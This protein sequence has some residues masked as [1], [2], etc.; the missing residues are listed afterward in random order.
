[1]AVA[2]DGTV[3][4][5]FAR[6][7]ANPPA[8]FV[9]VAVKP[10]GGSFGAPVSL[11]PGYSPRLASDAEGNVAVV[12]EQHIAGTSIVTG[13]TRRAGGSFTPVQKISDTGS[14]A[15]YPQV[16]IAG[17]KAVVVWQQGVYQRERVRA[18]S[19]EAGEPFTVHDPLSGPLDLGGRIGVAVARDGAAVVTWSAP[20]AS[21][22]QLSAAARPAEGAFAALPTV[23]TVPQYWVESS[24]VDVSAQGRATWAW[25]YWDDVAKRYVVQSASRGRHGRLRRRGDGRDV[26]ARRSSAAT[27]RSTCRPTAR[28]CW[29]GATSTCGTR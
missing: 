4:A 29:C 17:G 9:E 20:T 8:S 22:A 18:A 5:A 27:S 12:W 3:V 24:R 7:T 25:S 26:L 21:G 16:D 13:V 15:E 2:P 10:P 1:M 6:Q 19:A 23:A 14:D 11:G 28:P